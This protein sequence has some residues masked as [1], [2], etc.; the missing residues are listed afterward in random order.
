MPGGGRPG[1][2]GGV[3]PQAD[4]PLLTLAHLR[5]G[6]THAQ[7]AAGFRIGIATVHRCIREA[8]DVLAALAPTPTEAMKKR[9]SDGSHERNISH[10]CPREVLAGVA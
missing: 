5:C 8:I 4:R 1:R 9:G 3:C 7:L 6:D 2:A 10:G